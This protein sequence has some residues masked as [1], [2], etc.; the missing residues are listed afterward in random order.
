MDRPTR[1]AQDSMNFCSEQEGVREVAL[2]AQ[3][4]HYA[5]LRRAVAGEDGHNDVGFHKI[6]PKVARIGGDI[7]DRHRFAG[8]GCRSAQALVERDPLGGAEAADVGPST[9]ALKAGLSMK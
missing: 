4:R 9:R 6:R 5:L 3:F 2:N 1:A 7:V 8:G